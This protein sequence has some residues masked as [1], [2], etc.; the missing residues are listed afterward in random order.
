MFVFLKHCVGVF[1][2]FQL[3]PSV[4][5]ELNCTP[6]TP[7]KKATGL[8]DLDLTQLRGLCNLFGQHPTKKKVGHRWKI[9]FYFSR[10]YQSITCICILCLSI[11]C[12]IIMILIQMLLF[13]DTNYCTQLILWARN[14][15][16]K[17]LVHS[18]EVL[19]KRTPRRIRGCAVLVKNTRNGVCS[20]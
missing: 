14:Y 12:N 7:K 10:L 15:I 13:L 16:T 1:I 11:D 18:K 20:G 2:H 3:F 5:Y 19:R 8:T 6:N 17:S 4:V 9:P